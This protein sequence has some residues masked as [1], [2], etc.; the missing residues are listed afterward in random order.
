VQ[1]QVDAVLRALPAKLDPQLDPVE[2]EPILLRVVGLLAF[3]AGGGEMG[4]LI[5]AVDWSQNPLG[6]LADWPQSL[7]TAVSICLNSRFPIPI[8]WGPDL[9]LIYN[10]AWRPV[11]GQTKHPHALGSPGREVWPEIWHIIGPMLEGVLATGQAT[12]SDDQLLPLDRNGYLEEAYFTYSY[13]P[14]RDEGGKVGGVFSA[15]NET[16]LRVVG[17]RRLRTLRELAAQASTAKS[18]TRRGVPPS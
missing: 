6:P 4:A 12:W 17:E 1:V 14:I 15:V 9:R 18:R 8:W 2:D 3:V 5:R 11:L 7:K 16:T 10:D 13:S